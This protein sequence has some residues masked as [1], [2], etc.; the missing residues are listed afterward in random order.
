MAAAAATD[1]AAAAAPRAR[2]LLAPRVATGS[3]A[4]AGLTD[5]L[6]GLRRTD[7]DARQGMAAA[8]TGLAGALDR[9]VEVVEIGFNGGL[10]ASGVPGRS[11]GAGSGFAIT[12]ADAALVPPDI[13]EARLERVQGWSTLPFDRH[14]LRDRLM[15]LRASPWSGLTGDGAALRLAAA[16]AAMARLVEL[17]PELSDAPNPD[18]LVL[19]GGAF[20]AAPAAAILLAVADVIRRPSAVQVAYDHARLLGPLGTIEDPAERDRL[21][22]DLAGDLLAP[23][24]AIVMPA[25]LRAGRRAGRVSLDGPGGPQSIGMDVGALDLVPL[26]AGQRASVTLE[27]TDGFVMGARGRRISVEVA[28]GDAGLLIDLRGVPLRL[29]DRRE[30]RRDQLA[31]WQQAA[32]PDGAR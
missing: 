8:A 24:G 12:S 17:T 25:G 7:D 16:R 2:V 9:R 32:W 14:R 31:R 23:L 22:A 20:A 1:D 4:W 13:D 15:E 3:P 21:L 19:A 10:R 28:G 26:A 11:A 29:P 5:L 30:P 18:L 27:A 6:V